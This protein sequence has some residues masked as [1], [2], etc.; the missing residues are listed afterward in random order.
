MWVTRNCF[1]YYLI[2]ELDLKIEISP[3]LSPLSL[4]SGVYRK[5]HLRYEMEIILN[6]NKLLDMENK[7]SF[8][9]PLLQKQKMKFV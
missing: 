8:I 6:N 2:F 7:S 4:F 5:I 3:L 1:N 9:D